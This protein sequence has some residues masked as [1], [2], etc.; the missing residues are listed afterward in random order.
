MDG[1][2]GFVAVASSRQEL[3]RRCG[4]WIRGVLRFGGFVFFQEVEK[5]W[6]INQPP[7][8]HLLAPE[9]GPY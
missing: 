6:L 4:A 9:I 5:L 8:L 7:T 1:N 3:Q 2:K